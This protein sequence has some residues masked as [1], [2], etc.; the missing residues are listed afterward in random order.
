[1]N[2]LGYVFASL[3]FVSSALAARPTLRNAGFPVDPRKVLAGIPSRLVSETLTNQI[4]IKFT[5]EV[6]EKI[7]YNLPKADLTHAMLAGAAT[8][9]S[10]LTFL[11]R[12]SQTGWTV[13]SIPVPTDVNALLGSVRKEQGVLYA[14]KINKIYP[15]LADPNDADFNYEETSDD[16]ILDI[17]DSGA[18]DF[19]RL[20][21]LDDTNAFAGWSIWPNQ[22]YTASTM[23]THRPMIAVIDTGVDP[24]HPDFINAGGTGTTVPHGGQLSNLALSG[25]AYLGNITPGSDVTDAIVHGTHVTG[26]ALASANNGGYTYNEGDGGMVTDGILGMGYNC[27][28]MILKV[29]DNSGNGTDTD[30]AGAIYYAADNGADVINMSFGDFGNYSELLQDAVTYAFQKGSLVVAAGYEDA[31]APG[32]TI[33]SYPAGCSGCLA[34]EAEGPGQTPATD[35]YAGTGNYVDIGAPGGDLLTDNETYAAL[36]YVWSTVPEYDYAYFNPDPTAYPP[37][38]LTYTYLVG[39]SMASPQVAGA[40]GLYYGMMNYH[41]ADG[42]VNV[43]TI[44]QLENSCDNIADPPYN[45]WEPT[46]GYGGLDIGT[47]MANGTTRNSAVGSIKGMVYVQGGISGGVA[48]KAQLV[49]GGFTYITTTSVNDGSYRFESL[50]PGLY[51]VTSAPLGYVK[52]KQCQVIVGSD[53]PGF[54]LW[55][56]PYTG[57]T[58]PPTVPFFNVTSAN[59]TSFTLHQWGYD[60]E[61]GIDSISVQVGTSLGASNVMS[62]TTFV[63]NTNTSSFSG[64]SLSPGTYYVRGIYTNGGG[65]TTSVDTTF[66]TGSVVVPT[67]FSV[68]FGSVTSGNL[69]SLQAQDSNRMTIQ[70]GTTSLLSQSPDELIVTATAPTSTPN[71]L[72]AT[73]VSQV[74]SIN[75]RQEIDMFDYVANAWVIVDT[76]AG[77]VGTDGTVTVTPANPSRFIQSGTKAMQLRIQIFKSGF[78]SILIWSSRANYVQWAFS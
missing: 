5:P 38:W 42:Y 36:Q 1:M 55:C 46:F 43:Q 16:Y 35:Y 44:R 66:S 25:Q 56:G 23:P 64:L 9:I 75:L 28:G 11:S 15:L 60:T 18:Y 40:A 74:N 3:A 69:A 57:D 31:Q 50:P 67:G 39:S 20:W 72:T 61:T 34:V 13:W 51:N 26:L 7:A 54:D 32:G 45:S 12:I 62:P 68:P 77:S 17:D 41:Q 33:T 10:D 59:A 49:T 47:F 8:G 65:L 4:R 52:V 27:Q 78:N 30:A 21:Y 58:T 53:Q 22:Y 70:K 63:P 71:T 6:A 73:V 37:Y 48:V 29:F 24:N 19:R 14:E 76:R 2:R